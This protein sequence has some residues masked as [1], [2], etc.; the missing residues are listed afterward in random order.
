MTAKEFLKMKFP[1]WEAQE[2]FEFGSVMIREDNLIETMKEY[3][4][5]KCKEQR[6]LDYN[7]LKNGLSKGNFFTFEPEFD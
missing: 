7:F 5:E 1:L 4:R 2:K 3:A 6:Q